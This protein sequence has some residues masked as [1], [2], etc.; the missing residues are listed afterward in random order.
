M[1]RPRVFSEDS[2]DVPWLTAKIIDGGRYQA[3]L[4]ASHDAY[5][6]DEGYDDDGSVD[7]WEGDEES[8][9]GSHRSLQSARKSRY[10]PRLAMVV[11]LLYLFHVNIY[12][13]SAGVQLQLAMVCGVTQGGVD[14]DSA[15]VSAS[16][17][18]MTLV[19]QLA[20]S[21]PSFLL[22]GFYSSVANRYGRRLCHHSL[23]WTRFVRNGA[24]V[25]YLCERSGYGD[26]LQR[27]HRVHNC[28]F[29]VSRLERLLQRVKMASFS[30]AADITT[31]NLA[32]RGSFTRCLRL[33]CSWVKL[34][35]RSVRDVCTTLW[36]QRPAHVCHLHMPAGVLWC[37][38]VVKE[39]PSSKLE[40]GS[41]S[42]LYTPF[43][44][45][46]CCGERLWRRSVELPRRGRRTILQLTWRRRRRT[47]GRAMKTTR[48]VVKAGS[49]GRMFDRLHWQP[50]AMHGSSLLLLLLCLQRQLAC[51]TFSSR[52]PWAGAEPDRAYD[53]SEGFFQFLSMTLVPWL[54]VRCS[55]GMWTYT[56][57]SSA[58]QR[59]RPT[60][61]CWALPPVPPPSLPLHPASIRCH[62]RPAR[63]PL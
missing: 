12:P 34:S 4:G 27:H 61:C 58:I 32:K 7:S 2:A 49:W 9:V 37:T 57:C 51:G 43:A 28:G 23:A 13:D 17:G 19:T 1:V 18:R 52:T 25:A 15:E 50:Y 22:S 56:G 10:R 59:G 31:K 45:L 24:F 29:S 14:C 62:P 48:K 36:I 20:Q 21:V 44:I 16:T 38:L 53:A 33:L 41:F 5:D 3:M 11:L 54:I 30:Y 6:H 42:T 60:T 40:T 47:G 55:R 8:S 46:A 63:A 26:V 35:G 39:D